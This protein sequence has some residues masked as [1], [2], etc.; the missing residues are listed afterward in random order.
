M[1]NEKKISP[2]RKR[3]IEWKNKLWKERRDMNLLL[4]KIKT[5][6]KKRSLVKI[7]QLEMLLVKIKY[8]NN[9]NKLRNALKN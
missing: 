8:A 6:N 7:K 9:P 4:K 2:K 3:R 5:E 1:K